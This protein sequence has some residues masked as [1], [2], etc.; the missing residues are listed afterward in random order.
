[1]MGKAKKNAGVILAFTLTLTSLVRAE[2][3]DAAA[4]AAPPPGQLEEVI[5]TAQ[6]REESLQDVPISATAVSGLQ[7]QRAQITDIAGLQFIAPGLN[8]AT[9]I[10]DPTELFIS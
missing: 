3:N 10:V 7:L 2:P 9:T 4:T 5:V 8:T 6:R 1:M